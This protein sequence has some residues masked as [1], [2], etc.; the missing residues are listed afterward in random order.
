MVSAVNARAYDSLL[1]EQLSEEEI[2][3]VL[4]PVGFTDWRAAARSLVRMAKEPQA[5]LPLAGLLG[6]L[7]AAMSGAASPDRVLANLERFVQSVPTP[8]ALF[9]YLTDNPRTIEMLVM[10]F[11]GSQFL[12]EILLRNPEYL[13][14]L[15]SYKS[16][17]QPKSTD[18]FYLEARAVVAPFQTA[19]DRLDALRRFQRPELLRIGV[20]DLLDL[21]DLP[22][23]TG[24]LSNLA[25]GLVRVCLEIAA[26]HVNIIPDGF[27]VVALGKLGGRELNY[28]SDIDLLFLAAADATRYQRL[29]ERLIEGLA[30][31]TAEGF[32]Y[33]VD[34]RLRPWG[35]VGALVSSFDGYM[36]YLKEHARMW[37]KQALLKARVIAGDRPIGEAFMQQ[38]EALLFNSA[39]EKVRADVHGMKQRTEAHLRRHG[40]GWGEVKLG[41]GSIRDI[42]FVVQFLQLVHGGEHLEVRTYN[43]LSALMRLFG[44]GFVS[45]D[46]YRVLMDGYIFLRTVEH[47]L[48]MMHYRQT[49]TLPGDPEALT[50][51]ARRLG[52]QGE[53]AHDQFLARYQQHSAAIRAVYLRYLGG[54]QMNRVTN[55]QLSTPEVRR[56]LERMD[57]S[58][59][60]TFS[61]QEIRRHA[62]LAA[63]LDDARLVEVDAV[64]LDDGRWRV[65]I[66]AYD[67]PGE[68]SLICGL[69]FVYGFSIDDG[70]VFTY[71]P[72][73]NSS[74]SPDEGPVSLRRQPHGL[75]QAGRQ[76]SRRKIVDVFTVRS[77]QRQVAA[78]VWLRYRD[79]LAGLLELMR[80]GQRREARV[81]LAKRV[82]VVLRDIADSGATLYPVDIVIDNDTSD[83]YTVLRIGAPDTIGFLYEFTNALAFNRIYIARVTVDSVGNRVHDTLYV[84]DAEGQKITDPG[85]QRELRAATVLIKHFTHLLPHSPNPESALLHF[86]EFIGELFRHPDWPDE[87][88]SLERPEVLNALAQ[89]LGVSD[90]LW[91]DFL[92]MQYASLFPV[93]RDVDALA[94]AKSRDQLQAELEAELR[95]VHDGPQMPSDDA[96]W[97]G[98]LNDFKD[99]EMFRIDMRHILGYTREFDEFSQELTDLAEVIVNAAY[100]LCHED[101]RTQYGTPLLEDGQVSQLTVCAL[102]KFGGYELGFASDI[103][104]MFV[105]A[106]NGQT[107]GPGVI[108]TSEFYEKVVQ[109]FVSAIRAKREGIFEIDLQLR[110]YGKSSSL[111]VS[112]DAFRRYFAPKGPAWDYE[113]QALVKLRPVA[114][115][116]GLG[117]QVAALRD[118]FVYHGEPFDV[119]AMRAMRERQVRH[120]VKGGTFNAKYSPGGLVDLEYLVQG[121]QIT[122]G[123]HNPALRLT[124]TRKAMA[125]LADAGILAP[126]DYVRLRKAYTFLRWLIDALRVV[127][128]N[129]RDLTV[130]VPDSEEF[131]FLARRLRYGNDVAQLQGEL[132]RYTACVEELSTRLLS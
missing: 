92:R 79:D 82:A 55:S 69:L 13:E 44:S 127:R 47:H 117:Q 23:V 109:T 116:A 34:M 25:D 105:Y 81:E 66:V 99:R 27:A 111:A 114:G 122:H 83:Q 131:A 74:S 124:N 125:A 87:L 67:Y 73:V 37:E 52:F 1:R 89:L 26:D 19:V 36:A 91:D 110:P 49:C 130:P 76:D 21:F 64:P 17:A 72:M 42:E 94:T 29:A 126:G 85:K 24:Q 16:L 84:T 18:Q 102:G 45:G 61:E 104:L 56:H 12:T 78:D 40:R 5:R 77:T 121:L 96:P 70:H 90:F 65:T 75:Y 120:L 97:R 11:A 14:Q 93:V 112:L 68:L 57:P 20:C 10:L 33:R 59:G 22:T 88:A 86:R 35:H 106:G 54:N 132:L 80:S 118:Q 3:Q 100:H 101:L 8:H 128:G 7:L 95:L 113:R 51:L 32:L 46:E 43:T 28:S 53:G 71:E 123:H 119:T 39:A 6:Y 58:Y 60:A 62:V 4:A 115:D 38:A 31:V 103:E 98:T 2:H 48:Q 50:Q 63:H 129:A 15:A 41:E 107:T 30:R 9:D 108:T